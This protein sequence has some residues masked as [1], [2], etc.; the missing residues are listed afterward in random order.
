MQSNNKLSIIAYKSRAALDPDAETEDAKAAAQKV[1]AKALKNAKWSSIGDALVYGNNFGHKV[2]AKRIDHRSRLTTAQVQALQS[3]SEGY[4]NIRRRFLDTFRR[5]ILAD[6]TARGTQAIVDGNMAACTSWRCELLPMI[7]G[8]NAKNIIELNHAG[9][10][11][12]I[13]LLNAR[14]TLKADRFD[15]VPERVEKAWS[16]YVS[17]QSPNEDLGSR[18]IQTSNAIW[19][20]H[21][22][23]HKKRRRD[24]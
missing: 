20:A 3:T 10:H 22:K 2:L 13:R 4:L 21:K 18:L 6:D 11:N 16:E 14:A 9:D 8:L 17:R 23:A 15:C 24:A 7:Y 1:P 19:K 5:D 12:S